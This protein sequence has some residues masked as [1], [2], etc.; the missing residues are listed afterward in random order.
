MNDKE[1]KLLDLAKS[2]LGDQYSK[3]IETIE[4]AELR[5]GSKG[6]ELVFIGMKES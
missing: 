3:Y 2:I 1:N 6:L 4:S 5:I